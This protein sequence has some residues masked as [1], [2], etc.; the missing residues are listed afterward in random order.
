MAMPSSSLSLMKAPDWILPTS[1]PGIGGK[2]VD[3]WTGPSSFGLWDGPTTGGV[4][5]VVG[6]APPDSRELHLSGCTGGRMGMDA[7]ALA[8]GRFVRPPS[9]GCEQEWQ[10][11][12]YLWVIATGQGKLRLT[13]IEVKNEGGKL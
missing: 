6:D 12:F 7:R 1:F 13:R 5:V 4:T 2:S 10:C 9:E 11:R 8:G 3:S